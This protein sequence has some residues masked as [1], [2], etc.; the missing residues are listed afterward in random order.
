MF[1]ST[2]TAAGKFAMHSATGKDMGNDVDPKSFALGA[3]IGTGHDACDAER[4]QSPGPVARAVQTSFCV[5]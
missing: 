1:C 5:S 3:S 4:A 2:S